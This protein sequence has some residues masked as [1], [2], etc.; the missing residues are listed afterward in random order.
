MLTTYLEIADTLRKN[1]PDVQWI[2]LDEG[3]IQALL[4]QDENYDIDIPGIPAVFVGIPDE[5]WNNHLANQSQVGVGQLVVTLLLQLPSALH[6]TDPLI[7]LSV[8]AL[9]LANDLHEAILKVSDVEHRTR[10]RRFPVRHLFAVQQQ[11]EVRLSYMRQLRQ[12]IKPKPQIGV[13]M[14]LQFPIGQS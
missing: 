10:T 2:A 5:D 1:V 9:E 12:S 6:A 4:T 7:S 8:K 13:N 11:Y 14:N 3:Q